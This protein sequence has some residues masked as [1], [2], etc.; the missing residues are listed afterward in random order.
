MGTQSREQREKE[1]NGKSKP[2]G[3]GGGPPSETA[4]APILPQIVQMFCSSH[5]L[6]TGNKSNLP[7]SYELTWIG[8]SCNF[9]HYHPWSFSI[10]QMRYH[11]WFGN[12]KPCLEKNEQDLPVFMSKNYCQIQAQLLIFCAEW[13]LLRVPEVHC[14]IHFSVVTCWLSEFERE[15]VKTM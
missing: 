6:L 14:P 15:L 9:P 10:L 7:G 3:G 2:G 5:N 11:V 4:S 12:C 8:G 1:R 13:P